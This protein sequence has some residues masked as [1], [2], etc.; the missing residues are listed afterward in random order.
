M[1]VC[2][3][4]IE[5]ENCS[6]HMCNVVYIDALF[7]LVPSHTPSRNSTSIISRDPVLYQLFISTLNNPIINGLM[8]KL[9]VFS[10]FG[11]WPWN[12]TTTRPHTHTFHDHQSQWSK[13]KIAKN[14]EFHIRISNHM[15]RGVTLP[16]IKK[17]FKKIQMEKLTDIFISCENREKCWMFDMVF[18]D[19]TD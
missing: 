15:C 3:A 11:K 19:S 16:C 17:K 7:F 6:N 12:K 14:S 8:H 9:T 5:N 1:C 2:V 13:I 10:L 4:P 18:L